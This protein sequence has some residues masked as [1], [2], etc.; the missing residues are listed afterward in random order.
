MRCVPSEL[1]VAKQLSRTPCIANVSFGCEGRS[2][3]WVDKGCRGFFGCGRTGQ[4][5][6]MT[7][8]RRLERLGER[9]TCACLSVPQRMK[10]CGAW[11]ASR[12]DMGLCAC[13]KGATKRIDALLRLMQPS[14]T[15]QNEAKGGADL[16]GSSFLV[17]LFFKAPLAQFFDA[18]NLEGVRFMWHERRS[19]ADHTPHNCYYVVCVT[20]AERVYYVYLIEHSFSTK[21]AREIRLSARAHDSS[22]EVRR[23]P[24]RARPPC[25]E[26]QETTS[27][28]QTFTRTAAWAWDSNE[29][30]R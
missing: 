21:P 10:T 3:V 9:R 19:S 27:R 17:D 2:R 8:V 4:L 23:S 7:E 28:C 25:P 22:H 16:P 24:E 18:G 6:H 15:T 5:Q 13:L 26:N 20:K 14:T 1:A 11:Y 12:E 29:A 30:A